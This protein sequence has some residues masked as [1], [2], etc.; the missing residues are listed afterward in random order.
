[1]QWKIGFNNFISRFGLGIGRDRGSP[2]PRYAAPLEFTGFLKNVGADT[3]HLRVDGCLRFS[4]LAMPG[5][6][7]SAAMVLRPGT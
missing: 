6:T 7:D 3:D 4:V 2:M 1:M 5:S